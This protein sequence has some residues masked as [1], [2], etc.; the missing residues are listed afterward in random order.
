VLKNSPSNSRK[1]SNSRYASINKDANSSR[2]FT[3][4]GTPT[5]ARPKTTAWTHRYVG[6][7]RDGS[8]RKVSSHSR[9]S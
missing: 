5:T 6:S 9:N 4:A 7:S 1:V 2:E 8:N 3:T